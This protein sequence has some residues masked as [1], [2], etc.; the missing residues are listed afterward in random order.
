MTS[1]DG[2]IVMTD[3]TTTLL[4]GQNLGLGATDDGSLATEAALADA[5]DSAFETGP[6]DLEMAASANRRISER[7]GG[8]RASVFS[9]LADPIR[10][11]KAGRGGGGKPPGD[12]LSPAEK[13]VIEELFGGT[14]EAF[15]AYRGLKEGWDIARF[16][17]ELG[18][19]AM[20]LL[21]REQKEPTSDLLAFRWRQRVLS[22]NFS[23]VL[24]ESALDYVAIRTVIDLPTL[25]VRGRSFHRVYQKVGSRWVPLSFLSFRPYEFSST[26]LHYLPVPIVNVVKWPRSLL[27]EPERYLPMHVKIGER[28]VLGGVPNRFILFQSRSSVIGELIQKAGGTKAF[29]RRLKRATFPLP[30][31][32]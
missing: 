27:F 9:N 23:T 28:W 14:R 15:T 13:K 4:L 16:E 32:R 8:R 24:R 19:E 10:R 12:G 6:F 20:V 17:K 7:L 3:I 21:I 29:F 30:S 11:L 1:A 31:P 26:P 5:D 2:Y 22:P 25:A 18:K